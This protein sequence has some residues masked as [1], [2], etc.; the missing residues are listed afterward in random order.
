MESMACTIRA[1]MGQSQSGIDGG[2][3]GRR[4]SQYTLHS[5]SSIIR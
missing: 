3:K 4:P 5:V 1:A 2:E